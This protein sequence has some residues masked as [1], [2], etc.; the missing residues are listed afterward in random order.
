MRLYLMMALTS[1]FASS[2]CFASAVD[3]IAI[4]GG[5]SYAN[6]SANDSNGGI[7][8]VSSIEDDGIGLSASIV[9]NT[10]MT[11]Y[12]KPYLDVTLLSQDDRSFVIPGA[13]IRHDFYINESSFE[14]FYSFGVGYN[15]A[16]WSDDPVNTDMTESDSGQSIV[17]SAQTGF[18]Y[19]LNEHL[20]LDLTVRYDAYDIDTT[21]VEDNRVTRIED[22]GSLSLLAG[23][24]YRFGPTSRSYQDNDRDGIENRYDR[25]PDTLKNVPV[26]EAGCPQYHFDIILNFKFSEY[27]ISGLVNHPDFNSVAFLNKN[28]YYNV[29]IIGY[30]DS[31]GGSEFN[32][33]LSEQ[34][35]TEARQYLVDQGIELS[36]VDVL[37]RGEKEPL[38]ENSSEIKRSENRRIKIEFYRAGAMN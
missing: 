18:D 20:A 2:M 34:R 14:P 36:R 24:V 12:F 23:L 19:Y 29:H 33:K 25:C 5:Y 15:F 35:S 17:F 3:T 11:D 22:R 28:T 27:K 4:K 37:G 26:N 9:F 31:I 16:E 13:G 8:G 10:G 38:L 7:D 32:Q 6:S 1:L 21:I 30:S